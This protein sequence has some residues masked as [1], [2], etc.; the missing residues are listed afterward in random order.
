MTSSRAAL[1]IDPAALDQP[2]AAAKASELLALASAHIRDPAFG[3]MAGAR[4]RPELFGVVGFACMSAPT[5]GAALERIARYRRVTSGDWAEIHKGPAGA[6][7][8][9][10][11]GDADQPF[12]LQQLD[13]HFA[14]IIAFGRYLTGRPLV[15]Q[16]VAI[17]FPMPPHH[18]RYAEVFGLTP[19]F[20][21]PDNEITF[22]STALDLPLVS[23]NAEL[24]AIFG[25]KADERLPGEGLSVAERTQA[26]LRRSLRGELPD[27]AQVARTLVMSRRTLQRTLR[28]EGTSFLKLL[29]ATRLDLASKYPQKPGGKRGGGLLPARLHEPKLVLPSVQAMDG[30]DPG[31]VTGS[32]RWGRVR[33]HRNSSPPEQ[34][35]AR[36]AKS[37]KFM[38]KCLE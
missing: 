38:I 9:L 2:L 22:E 13:A 20:D 5:F 18:A 26:V 16:R 8:V 6:R 4:L 12:A 30:L 29:D 21:A 27:V 15:P 32:A 34:S 31:G 23:A 17:R 14:F 11:Q 37:A 3:L 36:Y 35:S 19:E 28:E 33:A 1:G 7:L 25:E 10:H 24:F